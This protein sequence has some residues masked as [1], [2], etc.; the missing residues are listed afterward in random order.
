MFPSLPYHAA[1]TLSPPQKLCP[2]PLP[3]CLTF[4]VTISLLLPV[5]VFGYANVPPSQLAF[6]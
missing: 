4:C 2:L 5:L 6:F 1:S 3:E